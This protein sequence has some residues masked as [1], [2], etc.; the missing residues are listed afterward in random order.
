MNYYYNSPA[1]IAVVLIK[2]L[3]GWLWFGYSVIFTIKNFPEKRLFYIIFSIVF[4]AWFIVGPLL[5]LICNF[6]IPDHIRQFVAFIIQ[7]VITFLG[8]LILLILIRPTKE[9]KMFPF[10]VKTNQIGYGN[11]P[12]HDIDKGGNTDL[13]DTKTNLS[14]LFVVRN[15]SEK[16]QVD[17]FEEVLFKFN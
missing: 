3:L 9:N 16:Y 4:S 5:I 10:H 12:H 13:G 15:S 7:S 6:F 2:M 17:S 14:N 8:H 11:Y 1:G